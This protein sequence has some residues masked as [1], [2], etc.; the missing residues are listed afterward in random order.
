MGTR[1]SHS[2][3]PFCR[4][5]LVAFA[6]C[7]LCTLLAAW[8]GASH[9]RGMASS[10]LRPCPDLN[11]VPALHNSIEI[12]R[13]RFADNLWQPR[14]SPLRLRE[15]SAGYPRKT[16]NESSALGGVYRASQMAR[17]LIRRPVDIL[18]SVLHAIGRQVFI[19]WALACSS[20][21]MRMPFHMQGRPRHYD[22]QNDRDEEE[23]ANALY[24]YLGQQTRPNMFFAVA[25]PYVTYG[26][27]ALWDFS[28]SFWLSL[29]R[30]PGSLPHRRCLVTD[31]CASGAYTEK[32]Q[33]TD[34]VGLG[35][36]Q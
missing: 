13:G 17:H 22:R 24:G 16:S 1:A 36:R 10:L 19:A 15:Q 4:A 25:S 28:P 14:R 27:G 32:R 2:H 5:V 6:V 29:S 18:V 30:L 21:V 11:L 31:A 9:I 12:F 8:Q 33:L 34:I 20:F 23:R 3:L 35:R 26:L 7:S